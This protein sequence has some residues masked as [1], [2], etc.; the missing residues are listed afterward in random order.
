VSVHTDGDKGECKPAQSVQTNPRRQGDAP[1]G[2]GG[3]WMADASGLAQ[4]LGHSDPCA[5]TVAW[6]GLLECEKNVSVDPP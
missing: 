6:R 4:Y 3:R 1:F 2:G 5:A